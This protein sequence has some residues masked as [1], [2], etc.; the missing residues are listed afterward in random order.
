M[1]QLAAEGALRAARLLA[2]DGF[3]SAPPESKA[4]RR[5]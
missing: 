2:L 5:R 3:H 4:A 1:V